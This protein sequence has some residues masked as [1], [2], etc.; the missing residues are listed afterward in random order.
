MWEEIQRNLAALRASGALPPRD[1]LLAV[2][3]GFPLQMAPGLPDSAGFRV[4]AFVDHNAAIGAVLD[5]NGGSR[6]YDEHRGTDYALY[7]FGWNKVDAGEV[8]VIAAAAGTI[9][10]KAD[11]DPT[12]HN[13]G[14]S[15][16]DPWNYVAL[17]HSDGRMTIYG[18]MR[19]GS[20]TS[21]S[22]GQ[23][24]SAGEYLGEA[25]SSGNSSGAHL[26]F[27]VRYG[28]YTSAEWIDP[29]AGPSSQ[30][31]SLWTSQ[32]PYYDSAINLLSTH[33][34]PPGT[35]DVCLPSNTRLQES[36]TPLSNIYVYAFYRDFQGTLGTDLKLYR[37]DGSV[38]GS[39]PYAPGS[40]AFSS[41]WNH[42]WVVNLPASEPAGPWRFEA[43]Y[44]GQTYQKKLRVI[45]AARFHPLSPCRVIDTRGA[46]APLAGPV[47][48]ANQTRVFDVTTT[49]A[50]CGIPST[51]VTLSVNFTVTAPE[52]PGELRAFPGDALST[53]TSVLS[54]K[55]GSTRANSGHLLLSADGAGT[56]KLTNASNGAAH[57]VLDVNGYYE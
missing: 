22:V 56:F 26:H 9:V 15:S 24:V 41:A 42:G 2:T 57:F 33:G 35:P 11:V 25:A 53:R 38:Y 20:V 10:A 16:A 28:G 52:Q 27:E 34:G 54:F 39:W 13:C 3:Y 32:R 6:T 1:S 47:L 31:Q 19:Y 14:V 43:T 55:A 44:N 18:H 12:D 49:P 4:S 17:T 5:Y 46:D 37:P 21:K 45:N 7:P 30:A 29:Y 50:V 48:A 36:F 51:A 40:P 8:Q 23:A